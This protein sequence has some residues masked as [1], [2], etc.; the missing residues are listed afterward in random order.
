MLLLDQYQILNLLLLL[1]VVVA[2]TFMVLVVE[3][4]VDIDLLQV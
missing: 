4:P 2:E 3:A 1:A